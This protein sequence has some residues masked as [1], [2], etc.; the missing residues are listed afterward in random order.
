MRI[1]FLTHFRRKV[2]GAETY[3]SG[4]L[5]ALLQ[6]GHEI[7]I[8]TQ[9]EGPADR[10][11]LEIPE[12]VIEWSLTRLDQNQALK[13]IAG[14]RPDV[15]FCQGIADIGFEA[16]ILTLAPGIF[17]AHNYQCTC[18][19]GSKTRTFPEPAPC[20]RTFGPACLL[21]YYPR[22]CGGLNPVTAL[23]RYGGQWSRLHSLQTYAAIATNSEHLADE[24]RRHGLPAQCLY[25][26][27]NGPSHENAPMAPGHG[28]PWRT[29][30]VGRMERI[31]G[32]GVLLQSLPQIL[33]E[34]GREIEL[35]FIGDGPEQA[36]WQR[37]ASQVEAAHPRIQVKFKGWINTSELMRQY[38]NA[39]L[40]I[41]PSLWPEPFG[42][43]GVEAGR[44]GVPAVAFAVGGIPEWLHDGENGYLASGTPPTA[45]G[46][47][48]AVVRALSPENY[49]RI[50]VRARELALRWTLEQHC[51]QLE[52]I[53]E[54]IISPRLTPA[55]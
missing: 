32:G 45:S 24:Y 41:V 26:F 40:L 37:Q 8:C 29:L 38:A 50:C 47:A 2:G 6:R 17:Y 54:R 9:V 55:N 13:Q 43:V 15:V 12:E 48:A 49:P 51:E 27:A 28:N 42:L 39:N 34:V 53:I 14:W 33:H 36:V 35:T 25:L 11:A 18:I 22:R 10:P 23:S 3:L 1:V 7:G 4:I 52:R 31:K 46:L 20:P 16:R 5:P 19:S 44:Q 21:Q 30:F